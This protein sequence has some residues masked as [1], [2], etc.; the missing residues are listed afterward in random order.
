MLELAF[1]S[2]RLL[3]GERELARIEPDA[4]LTCGGR[5]YGIYRTKKHGW[6][7][8]VKASEDDRL[9]CE[10]EPFRVLRGGRLRTGSAVLKLHGRPLRSKS[11]RFTS[12]AGAR[13]EVASKLSPRERSKFRLTLRVEDSLAPIPEAP[14]V[15]AFGCWLALNWEDAPLGPAVG[16]YGGP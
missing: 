12:D 14:I 4:S 3:E 16:P 5:E 9:V 11:W 10:F 6:H 15:L 7:Y 8:A 1:A 13:I 2:G